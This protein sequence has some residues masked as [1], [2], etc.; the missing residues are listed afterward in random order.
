[1]VVT[2]TTAGASLDARIAIGH[3]AV[4]HVLAGAGI[5]VLHIKGPTLD[6]AIV[7]TG[8]HSTDADVLVRDSDARRTVE[9]LMAAGWDLRSRF[10]NSSAFQHSATLWHDLWGYVDVHRCFPGIGIDPDAAFERLW[11]SHVDSEIAGVPCAVPDLPGQVLV[12][13]LHAARSGGSPRSRDDVRSAWGSASPQ[14]RAE[15]L[16]L[17]EEL[18]AEVAFA[19][20]TGHLD[21]FRDTREH[22]LWAISLRGG[23]RFQE[24]RARV[25]AAPGLAA[26]TR[27]AVRAPLVNV[28]HL[29]M[30]RGHPP[31]RREVVAE[32]FRR[33]LRGLSQSW[34][35]ARS[36]SGA[37]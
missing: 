13:L 29:A 28:D 1:V 37:R 10:E 25:K 2:A 33:P 36:R 35:S 23:T 20:A 21:D 19:A 7:W 17:V 6:P 5:A 30:I 22:D 32:F 26:A 31:T 11:A 4:Q 9:E 18:D 3:A 24:W 8:R 16:E 12:I 15:V 14:R 34:H 27:V